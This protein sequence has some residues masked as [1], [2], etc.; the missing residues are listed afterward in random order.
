MER[1]EFLKLSAILSAGFLATKIPGYNSLTSDNVFLFTIKDELG[2]SKIIAS[3]FGITNL[4]SSNW[5]YQKYDKDS[6]QYLE[7]IND[8]NKVRERKKFWFDHYK[9]PITHHSQLAFSSGSIK[10]GTN[11]VKTNRKK[12]NFKITCAAGG[13]V[14]GPELGKRNKESGHWDKVRNKDGGSVFKSFSKEDQ[15]KHR[16]MGGKVSGMKNVASGQVMIAL[17]AAWKTRTKKVRCKLTGK[18][19]DSLRDCATEN[20]LYYPSLKSRIVRS[21]YCEYEYIQEK[22]TT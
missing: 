4:K 13:R 10:G 15:I 5:K 1:R 12:D 2:N 16:S 14:F 20:D 7:T 21:K 19:W 17:Q 8:I 11:A 6:F 22:S 3:R 18:V 9:I